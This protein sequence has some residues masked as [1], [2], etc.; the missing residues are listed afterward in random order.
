MEAEELA[1]YVLQTIKPHTQNGMV[2][3]NNYTSALFGSQGYNDKGRSDIEM[4]IAEAWNWLEVQGL[5]VPASGI[6]GS[7]GFR[8]L[9]RRAKKM[10]TA[11]DVQ[12]FAK[13]R[14]IA[15]QSL[16]PRIAEKVWSAFI[17]GEFDVA[18][19]QA[20]KAV[21]I[22]VREAGGYSAADIG[23]ALMRK[24]FHEDE[25]TLTDLS[26]ERAERQARSSL[27]AGT[28]GSYKNPHSHRDVDINEAEEAMELVFLANH[29]LRIIDG[30]VRAK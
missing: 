21:E 13:S 8:V 2:Y 20:M 3:S 26:A 6:N 27:F 1:G 4:A 17:R 7:N 29:L 23:V 19:F 11:D 5:L 24:A 9:S 22:Y 30:R 16:H 14:M 28:I 25:G 18:V 10:Q 15:R 12:A